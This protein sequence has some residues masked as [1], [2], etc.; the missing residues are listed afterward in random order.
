MTTTP[1]VPLKPSSTVLDE[2]GKRYVVGDHLAALI[3]PT[4]ALLAAGTVGWCNAWLYGGLGLLTKT[5]S[6]AVLLR[7]NPAVLNARGIKRV[8]SR[9]ERRFFA[10]FLP[11]MLM[12]PVV[13]GLDVGAVGWTHVSWGALLGGVTMVVIGVAILI[14]ALAVNPHF[15][16][17]VRIQRDRGHRVCRSGPYRFVRHPGYVAMMLVMAGAPLILGSAWAFAPVVVLSIALVARTR[18]ED[19]MLH[20]ELVGYHAYAARTRHRL[21]PYVW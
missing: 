9:R 1:D 8:M 6:A 4:L 16:A 11:A 21:V 18:Y 7:A 20:D 3:Q 17:T 14:W 12:T 2:S 5:V 19:R 15:E 10:V 13:A